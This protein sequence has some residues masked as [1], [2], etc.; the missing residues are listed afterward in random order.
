MIS[1]LKIIKKNCVSRQTSGDL[2]RVQEVL[3]DT[4][5]PFLVGLAIKKGVLDSNYCWA[6]FDMIN[7]IG[8]KQIVIDEQ[9]ML[10][11]NTNRMKY[12]YDN[13]LLVL[14]NW[15]ITKKKVKLG[16]VVDFDME[17]ET[18]WIA[19][20]EV[21]SGLV[22]NKKRIIES[23]SFVEVLSGG[24]VFDVDDKQRVKDE[25]VELELAV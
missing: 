25:V 17:E 13:N 4:K 14:G 18:G 10:K 22:G 5:K 7:N 1:V 3:V 21:T 20:F 6:D 12:I 8:D 11:K 2:G 19:S 24:V 15:A 16:R 9:K 23:S